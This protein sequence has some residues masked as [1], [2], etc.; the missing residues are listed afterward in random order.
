MM[1]AEGQKIG[2]FDVDLDSRRVRRDGQESRLSPKAA[3]VLALLMSANGQVVARQRL[4]DEVWPD[5]TVGEEVLTQAIAE[6]RRVFGDHA[7][8]PRYLETISKSGYRLLPGEAVAPASVKASETAPASNEALSHGE[9]ALPSGPSVVV[10]PFET[11]AES[12][13]T[14]AISTGLSRDI[15]VALA[16]SRWLF[17]TGRGSVAVLKAEEL[18]PVTLARR[19]GVR[20]ALSGHA[21][22]DERRLRASVQLCDAATTRVVW[23]ET[24]D[25]GLDGVFDVIDAIGK[26]I[27]TSVETRIEAHMRTVARLKPIEELDAWGLYHRAEGPSR[28]AS[29]IAEVE[30]AHAILS[31]AV[32]L[33]PDAA[34]ISAALASLEFRRQLLFEPLTST[35][36]LMRCVDLAGR[37]IELDSD[38]PDGLVAMGCA[39]GAMGDR[40]DGLHHLLRAVALNP[41]SYLARS[42]CAW[43]LLFVGRN[44][45]ALAHADAGQSIS[46]LD[47]AGFHMSAIRA[48][49][50]T[51]AG[52]VEEGYRAAEASDLH[53]RSSHL[54]SIIAV[55]CAVAAGLPDRVDFHV[56]RLR[57]ARPDFGLEDYFKL[58]PFEG[59]ARE[60]IAR[61]LRAA[62][63]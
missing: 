49:A 22:A 33:A 41:S 36:A 58:F 23:A 8:N 25:C 39:M 40:S 62:G 44:A 29:T 38:E 17:V 12:P 5:V 55:W 13:E 26:Q 60:T 50:L 56:A 18:D 34:R 53:P 24:F 61:Y 35:D 51:L 54:A 19:L 46:P 9:W 59:D 30:Q 21:M 20:Y 10:M 14:M 7:R 48:H 43:A 47:P 52:E 15:A 57:A 31:R 37:A 42:F 4:L 63:L 16:R 28:Y 32:T 6:L 45:D 1:I 11:I 27:A 2:P 3:G